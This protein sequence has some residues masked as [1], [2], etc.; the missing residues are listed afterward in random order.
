MARIP[1]V[2]R[3]EE[4]VAGR[5]KRSHHPFDIARHLHHWYGISLDEI[6]NVLLANGIHARYVPNLRTL[7]VEGFRL[8]SLHGISLFATRLLAAFEGGL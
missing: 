5:L 2:A 1:L 6:A 4:H 3:L 8:K 7:Y